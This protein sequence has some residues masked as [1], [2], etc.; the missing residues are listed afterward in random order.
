MTDDELDGARAQLAMELS[1]GLG[2]L[3]LARNAAALARQGWVPEAPKPNLRRLE[4]NSLLLSYEMH[5]IALY[6]YQR[7]DTSIDDINV[8]LSIAKRKATIERIRENIL[9]FADEED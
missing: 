1:D 3:A 7:E 6:D 9:A 8:N 2:P 4:L 5:V